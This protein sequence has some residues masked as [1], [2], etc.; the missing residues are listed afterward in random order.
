MLDACIL[1]GLP[2]TDFAKWCA[3]LLV[4]LACAVC[5]LQR[6]HPEIRPLHCASTRKAENAVHHSSSGYVIDTLAGAKYSLFQD[7]HQQ[8]EHNSALS[9]G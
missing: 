4:H 6:V 3:M 2:T 9:L 8:Q 5:H 1:W 7:N